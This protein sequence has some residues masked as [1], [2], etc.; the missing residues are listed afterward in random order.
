[1]EQRGSRLDGKVAIVT[2]GGS[3]GPG[4]G[5]GKA[6]SVLFAR[7]AA[8]VLVV[9]KDP[10]RGEETVAIIL[11]EGGQASVFQADVTKSR[12]C[13]QMVEAAIGRYGRLDILV[14]NV[15]IRRPGTVVDVTEEDWDQVMT[16]NLK[17]VMLA[18]KHAVPRMSETGGGAI[19][20]VSSISGIRGA[21]K[22][23]ACYAASKGGMIALTTAMAV[24]HGRSH[25]RVNAIAPGM[26]LTPMVASEVSDKDRERR[27]L[28]NPLGTE[29]NAWDV[30]WAAV[31]LASDEARWVTGVVLPVDGGIL[32]THSLTLAGA[33]VSG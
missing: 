27:R 2:G 23:T 6:I 18:S 30:A 16:V 11:K 8:K 32:T 20:N 19:V 21:S 14:N 17:S 13:Q 1:M 31:F 3:S 4:V 12:D 28:A 10:G 5:T 24:Q 33:T 29:G 26:I 15:G 7:Q 22:K 25:I 9:D